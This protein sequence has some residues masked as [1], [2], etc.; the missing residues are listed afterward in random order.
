MV[1]GEGERLRTRLGAHVGQRRAGLAPGAA[2]AIDA[3]GWRLMD[4]ATAI[5]P[6]VV[7]N[8]AA[9]LAL[10]PAWSARACGCR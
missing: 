7:G 6:L 1:G 4:A 5:R 2:T 8:N 9:A 3:A 10:R